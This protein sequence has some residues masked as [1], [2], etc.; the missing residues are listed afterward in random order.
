MIQTSGLSN[1]PGAA[2]TTPSTNTVRPTSGEASA[3]T[4]SATCWMSGIVTS[5]RNTVSTVACSATGE[6]PWVAVR[7]TVLVW[8]LSGGMA[9]PVETTRSNETLAPAA[10]VPNDQVTV[11]APIE[12]VGVAVSETY[13]KSAGSVST[14]ST[15]SSA[16]VVDG[17]L[18]SIV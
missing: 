8:M 16:S 11:P 6:P 2:V 3:A 17:L 14:S 15:L 5:S 4:G 7:S 12:A 9:A 10:S 1:S 18:N 13:A